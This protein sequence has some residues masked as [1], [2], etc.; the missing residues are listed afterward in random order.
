MSRHFHQ[1]V[2]EHILAD[3]ISSK[4][5]PIHLNT[6]E[7]IY[8]DHDPQ[9][10]MD[11]ATQSAEMG[12][13]R[14]IID[15]GWFRNRDGDKAALGDWYLDENKY[16]DGLNGIVEHVNRLGME[17]GL[18]FEPEMVNKDSDLYRAHPEWLLAVEGYDQPTGRNQYAINLQIDEA[19]D[20]LFDRLDYFLSSYNIEYIKWD[21]NR[22]IVQPGHEG[23][24]SGH[25][26]VER[27]YQLVDKLVAKY[28]NVE[29]ESCA[30]G[31]GRI[32][33]EVL[34]RT[35]RFWASDNNDAL[36]RQQIQRS[37]SY[38]F[39]P[40]VMGC[41]IGARHC[42]STRRTHDIN[43]RGLTALFGHMGIELDPVKEAAEE[44]RGLYQIYRAAQ[45]TA[46]AAAPR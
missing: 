31:G 21:M 32:D 14:F 1:H 39:P 23:F 46:P 19:F 26:Q 45:T 18:W 28:P 44:K 8:F 22:E 9:Y 6:W 40:E 34:K 24:A 13:E 36:E 5:R 16:P 33:F 17:F 41:H 43:F 42:H 11:M 2:R 4:P 35:V 38:F 29:I 25:K 20:Y 37:M 7:G 15:D 12:V 10:I 27:Y 30:A 3:R